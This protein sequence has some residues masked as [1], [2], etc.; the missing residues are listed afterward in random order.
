MLRVSRSTFNLAT[1]LLQCALLVSCTPAQTAPAPA[2]YESFS[3]LPIKQQMEEFRT[4][5]TSK[6]VDF[7]IYEFRYVH[8][9][10][11]GLAFAIAERGDEAVSY[12]LNRIVQEKDERTKL[13]VLYLFKI[14]FEHGQPQN[15]GKTI[16]ALKEVVSGMSAPAVKASAEEMLK[17]IESH[18][19]ISEGND[20]GY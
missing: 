6:Q 20:A 7:F 11:N 1:I 8:P 15:R 14:I 4:Y 12:L 2:G 3:S 19:L 5:P 10:S 17:A 9:F 18:S 13:A 16:S